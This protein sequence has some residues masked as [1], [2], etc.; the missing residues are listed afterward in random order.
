MRDSDS[1]PLV[2]VGL[3]SDIAI[4]QRQV[5]YAAA[6][7]V[8]KS[9]NVPLLTASALAQGIYISHCAARCVR[10]ALMCTENLNEVFE[11]AASLAEES[12]NKYAKKGKK[13]TNR[14]CTL[15]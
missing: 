10:F 4:D 11:F 7:D 1:I 14:R 12:K 3:K 5:T 15:Q 8:A 6:L 2:L 9:L 13:K